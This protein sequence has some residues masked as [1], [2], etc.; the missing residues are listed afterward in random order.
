MTKTV[1]FADV[2][3]DPETGELYMT[4]PME[5]IRE[6]GWEIG[7]K[8]SWDVTNDGEVSLTKKND[9]SL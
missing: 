2:D 1:W 7:D 6:L 8:L 3:E 4:V 5:L 9:Q